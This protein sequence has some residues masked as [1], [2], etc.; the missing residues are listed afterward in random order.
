MTGKAGDL[1]I[2]NSNIYHASGIN[3]TQNDR[4]A[5]P[6]TLSLPY[7]KQLIDY[8]RALGLGRQSEFNPK[9]QELLGYHSTMAS[10]IKDWYEPSNAIRYR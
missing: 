6:I 5:I 1:V 4:L 8:P 2:W 9:M 3:K 7:Y 10:S